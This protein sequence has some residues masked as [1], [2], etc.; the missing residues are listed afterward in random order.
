MAKHDGKN[1]AFKFGAFTFPAGSLVSVDWPRTRDELEATGATQLDKE[2]YPSER[3]STITVNAW[4]DVADTI[5]AAM[6][7]STA[8]ATAEYWP[9]GNSSGKPKRSASA[10]VTSVS[11]PQT[12]NQM[13]AITI[14]FRVNGAVTPSTVTP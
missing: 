6:E 7:V 1:I 11:D 13:A 2:F 8:E 4:D 9:Q 3:S 10:F 14:T 12:H 5:R